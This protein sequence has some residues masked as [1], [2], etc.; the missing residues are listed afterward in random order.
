MDGEWDGGGLKD[1]GRESRG[2]VKEGRVAQWNPPKSDS[3]ERSLF[4]ILHQIF[5]ARLCLE[6]LVKYLRD[7]LYN[8]IAFGRRR[9]PLVRFQVDHYQMVAHGGHF[10]FIY[11]YRQGSG[12]Q[13]LLLLLYYTPSHNQPSP[14]FPAITHLYITVIILP[15]Q[16]FLLFVSRSVMQSSKLF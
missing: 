16:F 9:L 7:T 2:V 1:M 8:R 15:A 10:V 11:Y 6:Y 12:S 5:P 4:K 3:F 14:P 13:G